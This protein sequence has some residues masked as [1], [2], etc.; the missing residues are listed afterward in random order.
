ML[1]VE[2]NA[3]VGTFAVQTLAD[4][5]YATVLATNA[6]Q[7]LAELEADADRFDVV[8]SDV[9]MPGMDGIELGQEIRPPICQPSGAVGLGLQPRAGAERHLRVRAAA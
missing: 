3:D 2:D 8:F 4:L 9:V 7:A 1:V 5:G 6:T